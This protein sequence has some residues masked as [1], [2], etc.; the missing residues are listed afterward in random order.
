MLITNFSS[1]EISPTLSGRTDLQQYYQAA[2]KIENFN[3]IPTGGIKRRTGF[4]RLGQLSGESRIIPF[5]INKD[6]NF[7]IECAPNYFYIW[8]NGD[9]LIS[10]GDQVKIAIP[11]TTLSSV[12]E[13]QYCQYYNNLII[14]HHDYKPVMITYNLATQQFSV[15][16]NGMSFN[17]LPEV[18]LDDQ[19]DYIIKMT[20]D[21]MDEPTHT[22]PPVYPA[23]GGKPYPDGLFAIFKN[24][25]Y[26]WD[27]TTNTWTNYD[28]DI[29]YDPDLL[30][31]E[32]KRPA[33]CTFFNGRLYFAS[34]LQN[35]QSVWASMAPDTS[36]TRYFDFS[37][38]KKYVTVNKVVKDADI[39]I[40]SGNVTVGSTLITNVTQDFSVPG[41]LL[42]DIS[43]YYIT[44]NLFP[45]GTKVISCTNNTIT[46]SN[47]A[48]SSESITGAALSISLWKNADNPSSEDYE[49]QILS[50]NVVT[51]DCSF[52]FDISSSENDAIK[53][54][55]C[56]KYL[57]IGTETSVWCVPS[58][59]NALSISAEM[60][61]K[62]GSDDIQ[63]LCIDTATVFFSQG[64]KGIREFYY[65]ADQA[66]F[67]TNNIA[68][69]AEEL[70]A[71][72]PAVDF[73]YVT[74][75]YNKLIITRENGTAV[76]LMYD[77]NN[78]IMAWSR[79][80]HSTGVHLLSCC[81]TSGDAEND[82]VYFVVKDDE[83]YYLERIDDAEEV[84]LDS[85]EVWEEGSTRTTHGEVL[86]NV[87][88]QTVCPANAISDD[89]I[90]EG[91]LVYVGYNYCSD[92][93]SLPVVNSQ[94]MNQKR[95]VSLLVRFL[96][97]YMPRMNVDGTY[98]YFSNVP[99]V[100]FSGVQKVNYPGDSERDVRFS[101]QTDIPAPVNILSINADVR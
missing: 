46:L 36:G 19:Y 99:E 48:S 90:H 77:R 33:C 81:V 91:D 1:G 13:L 83:E 23:I 60:S 88:T 39:H 68:I 67:R 29:Q 76:Q 84:Y 32:N 63:A 89:F 22:D 94:A 55:S 52:N 30:T 25:I 101:M 38:Y 100:P 72:S 5:I 80:T 41:L 26:K 93:M 57:V 54:L 87:T 70:L 9:K 50:R 4:K 66:A 11:Y 82:L 92:I 8:K 61:G 98:E 40:F 69:M 10:Q 6:V 51:S 3:I 31:A 47:P 7:I 95:I 16:S 79:I 35:R 86:L 62:Y 15:T 85:W 97:S 24:A 27:T 28:D 18:V 49:Y 2:E 59:V 42:D 78:G 20:G 58:A 21:T 74:N 43:K 75:P 71:E 12:K 34:S 17:F 96:D 64:K 14:T 56:N 53:W 44:S 45:I 73:D 37:T 65:Q